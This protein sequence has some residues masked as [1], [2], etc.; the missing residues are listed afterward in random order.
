MILLGD[1]LAS[2]GS[3]GPAVRGEIIV[4]GAYLRFSF[5]AIFL[6]YREYFGYFP[7]IL[8]ISQI[9]QISQIFEKF[10]LFFRKYMILNSLYRIEYGRLVGEIRPFYVF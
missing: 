4:S 5:A 1:F 7:E 2:Q 8:V 9:S 3:W 6:G 10:S